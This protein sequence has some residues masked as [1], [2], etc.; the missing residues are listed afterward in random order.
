ME[1][2]NVRGSS[3]EERSATAENAPTLLVASRIMQV[4]MMM[5]GAVR[6]PARPPAVQIRGRQRTAVW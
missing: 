1:V 4:R 2:E 3:L 5:H 6:R